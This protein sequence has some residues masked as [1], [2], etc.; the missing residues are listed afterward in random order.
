M[1]STIGLLFAGDEATGRRRAVRRQGW[2]EASR[3]ACPQLRIAR[4]DSVSGSQHAAI[5]PRR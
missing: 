1:G 5:S 4:L 2:I 3:P